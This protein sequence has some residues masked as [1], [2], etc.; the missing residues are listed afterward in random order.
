[1]AQDS[2]FSKFSQISLENDIKTKYLLYSTKFSKV[3]NILDI[4]KSILSNFLIKFSK[5][6]PFIPIGLRKLRSKI[7]SRSL[8]WV[9][10]SG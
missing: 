5:W 7:F 9:L 8:F 3:D 10:S 1:M 2:K 4:G 6:T